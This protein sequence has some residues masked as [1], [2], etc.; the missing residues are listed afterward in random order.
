VT[1]PSLHAADAHAFLKRHLGREVSRVEL[2]GEGAWS[3]CFGFTDGDEHFAI[4]FGRHV[5]D[6]EK[7]R[8][9]TTFACEALPVPELFEIGPAFDGHFAISSRAFGEPLEARDATGWQAVI[10]SLLA[11][12]DA[13][14][15][16]EVPKDGGAGD[17]DAE[18]KAKHGSW[19]EFLLTVDADT[20]DLRTAGWRR[21]LDDSP[22]GDRT[23]R[24]G[25][26]ELSTLADADADACGLVHGDLVNRNVLVANDRITAVFD[27]GCSFYGDRLYDVAWIEFWRPWLDGLREIDFLEIARRHVGAGEA[28][29]EP[30]VRACMIHIGLAHLAY[31]AHTGQLDD[32]AA[33]EHR[34]Q[35][36]L[37]C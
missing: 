20:P 15:S 12:L 27:W 23:F 19:R 11:A 14:R 35:G 1:P 4:R 22:I 37:R 21:R 28:D 2:V 10:P 33:T 34:L 6:F 26:A 7:D 9:A 24:I 31:H 13:M 18:G 5:D 3:R 29:F 16:V 30:R 17:W 36:L 32:L 25:L 8:Y